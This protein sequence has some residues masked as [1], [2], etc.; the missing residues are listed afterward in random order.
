MVNILLNDPVVREVLYWLGD[1]WF[2]WVPFILAL[3]FWETWVR[4]VRAFAIFKRNYIVLEIKIPRD[5]AK[6]PQAMESIFAGIHGTGR[7]GNLVERY[8]H[9]WVTAWFSLEIVGDGGEIHFYIWTHDFFKKMIESQ[10]YAQYPDAEIFEVDDYM[11][12]YPDSMPDDQYEI[13]GGELILTK[14]DA[15][16]IRTYPEFEEDNA[17]KDD[18]KRIDPLASLS[19]SMAILR[20]GFRIRAMSAVKVLPNLP[21]S[22]S[23]ASSRK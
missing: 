1:T 14:P 4:Y 17:G 15:Y 20:F 8:W 5:V 6:S 9:G 16:P 7:S 22:C 19:Q 23:C 12:D 13:T 2:L 10:I 21:R 3:L 18:L 11:A